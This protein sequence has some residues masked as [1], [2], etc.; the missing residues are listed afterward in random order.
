MLI[1]LIW[2]SH[3][4]PHKWAKLSLPNKHNNLKIRKI[5]PPIPSQEKKNWYRYDYA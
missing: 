4:V 1:T 3:I 5:M 2:S